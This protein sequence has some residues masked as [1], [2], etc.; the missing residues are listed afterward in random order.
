MYVCPSV[1]L[2]REGRVE[3]HVSVCMCVWVYVYGCA[4]LGVSGRPG[5][6]PLPLV[7]REARVLSA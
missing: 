3:P 1:Q 5:V 6:A 7:E 4:R 2:L